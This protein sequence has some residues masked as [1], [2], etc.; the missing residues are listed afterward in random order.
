MCVGGGGWG[1]GKEREHVPN[2]R[3]SRDRDVRQ[4][5]VVGRWV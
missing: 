5:M 3:V 4:K 1:V 2:K